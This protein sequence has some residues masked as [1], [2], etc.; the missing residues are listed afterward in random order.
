MPRERATESQV[1]RFSNRL[2]DRLQPESR[3]ERNHGNLKPTAL[4]VQPGDTDQRVSRVISMLRSIPAPRPM[5][6]GC[7]SPN[8]RVPA[9]SDLAGYIA[10]DLESQTLWPSGSLKNRPRRPEPGR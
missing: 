10:V 1:E 5:P 4:R 2:S 8:R 9:R 6:I 7:R 3:L